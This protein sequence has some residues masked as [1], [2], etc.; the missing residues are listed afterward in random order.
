MTGKVSV[1]IVSSASLLQVA[2][3]RLFQPA[4]VHVEDSCLHCLHSHHNRVLTIPLTTVNDISTSPIRNRTILKSYD[5]VYHV[6]NIDDFSHDIHL[7]CGL[8]F[9]NCR[10]EEFASDYSRISRV[11]LFVEVVAGVAIMRFP[12][13]FSTLIHMLFVDSLSFQL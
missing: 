2:S 3:S 12:F 8:V 13:S 10:I 1:L 11:P 6:D 9:R 5:P 7:P 4:G